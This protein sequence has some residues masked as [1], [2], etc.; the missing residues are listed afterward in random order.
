[1]A[2]QLPPPPGS[3]LAYAGINTTVP[4]GWLFCNGDAVSRTTYASLFAVISTYYGAGDGTTTFNVPSLTNKFLYG[5]GISQTAGLNQSAGSATHTLTVAELPAH[6]HTYNQFTA[7]PESDWI[8]GGNNV[9][10]ELTGY[11]TSSTTGS[12]GS[13]T[14]FSILPPYIKMN[15]IIKT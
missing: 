2:F 5:A 9:Y 15:Y 6:T 11:N 1:M 7:G 12:T 3:I 8:G 13:G 10:N 14:A 4:S